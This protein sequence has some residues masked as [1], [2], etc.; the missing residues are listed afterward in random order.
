MADSVGCECIFLP[1]ASV[2][3]AVLGLGVQDKWPALNQLCVL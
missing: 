2:L 3:H 1:L